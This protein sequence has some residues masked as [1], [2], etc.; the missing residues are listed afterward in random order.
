M[1]NYMSIYFQVPNKQ[2]GLNEQGG[3]KIQFNIIG[4]GQNKQGEGG[5]FV[6]F[7]HNDV[8]VSKFACVRTKLLFM[9][10]EKSAEAK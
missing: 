8:N 5:L 1:H 7:E 6:P 9:E 10:W 3:R 4:G 2:G